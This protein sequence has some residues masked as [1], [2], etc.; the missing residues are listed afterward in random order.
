M[1][2][3]FS[4]PLPFE[5]R[6]DLATKLQAAEIFTAELLSAEQDMMV[7]F[8]HHKRLKPGSNSSFVHLVWSLLS[9]RYSEDFRALGGNAVCSLVPPTCNSTINFTYISTRAQSFAKVF[10]RIVHDVSPAASV[11]DHY[12]SLQLRDAH[13]VLG[14]KLADFIEEIYLFLD[15]KVQCVAVVMKM[16][17]L[18]VVV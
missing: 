13:S 17:L 16:L 6:W 3:I 9:E 5:A 14:I 2:D 4:L 12:S 11:K 8:C 10:I 1:E 15:D 18:N 7:K